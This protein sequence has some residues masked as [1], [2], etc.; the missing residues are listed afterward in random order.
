MS[1][2]LAPVCRK[3]E[4]GWQSSGKRLQTLS[5]LQALL[6]RSQ[7]GPEGIS[8]FWTR[9]AGWLKAMDPNFLGRLQPLCSVNAV[10]V[11]CKCSKP[12][13]FC[14]AAVVKVQCF[15]ALLV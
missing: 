3:P 12:K 6:C 10:K 11:Q 2:Q 15:G 4:N 1:G 8:G 7:F 14:S 9:S 5:K 13:C